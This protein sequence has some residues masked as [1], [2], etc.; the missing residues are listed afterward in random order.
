[1]FRLFKG[2]E[3]EAM[4]I[5]VLQFAVGAVFLWFGIDKWVHPS[6]WY[7]W[8]PPWFIA[9]LP[10]GGLDSFIYLNGVLEVAIGIAFVANRFVAIA[11]AIASAFLL[12]ISFTVGVN[13]VT[14]RDS[15]LLGVCLVLFINASNK[16]RWRLSPHVV[17]TMYGAYIFYLFLYGV[18]YLRIAP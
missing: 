16:E 9:M 17:S 2:K 4:Q 13:E 14:I 7:G 5:T 8:I 6:A 10:K 1:M 12:A 3:T 11:A 18:W 15:A